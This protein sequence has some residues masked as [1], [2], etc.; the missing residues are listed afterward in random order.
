VVV[1]CR[2]FSTHLFLLGAL[3]EPSGRGIDLRLSCRQGIGDEGFWLDR[4]TRSK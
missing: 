1:D 3:D 4:G 2:Y